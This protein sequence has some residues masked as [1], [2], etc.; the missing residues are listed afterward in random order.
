MSA[1]LA[2]RL[3]AERLL[4][5]GRVIITCDDDGINARATGD[6]DVYIL[7]LLDRGWTCPCSARVT[8]SHVVAV[9]AVTGWTR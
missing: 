6:H 4:R 5:D 2:I 7:R 3:N 8:C 1:S 9:E